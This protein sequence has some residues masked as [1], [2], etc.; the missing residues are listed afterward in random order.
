[1][2]AWHE[3]VKARDNETCQVCGI[4]GDLESHH[5]FGRL[6]AL[7][8]DIDNGIYLCQACHYIAHQ[9]LKQF[10]KWWSETYPERAERLGHLTNTE[11]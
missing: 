5:V 6:G 3:A 8:T 2:K 1:M 10:R 11:K 7:R 9:N 4:V